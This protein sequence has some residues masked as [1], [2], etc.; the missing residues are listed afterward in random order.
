M[1]PRLKK[2]RAAQ[3]N[4]SWAFNVLAPWAIGVGALVSFTADAGQDSAR[5]WNIAPLTARI[6]ASRALEEQ[7]AINFSAAA[8]GEL[9]EV[10]FTQPLIKEAE[11]SLS[12]N[13]R[14]EI[15]LEENEP[16]ADLKG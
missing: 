6:R 3:R 7:Q 1:R 8:T 13:E 10:K 14:A 11:L 4:R 15:G 16:H 9:S 2:R 5:D 12:G